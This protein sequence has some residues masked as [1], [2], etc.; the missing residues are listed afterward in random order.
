MY[1]LRPALI[2]T[3]SIER[4]EKKTGIQEAQKA[5]SLLE[6]AFVKCSKGKAFF[7]G[8]CIGYLDMAL[9]CFL[10]WLR[11]SE[12][13]NSLKLLDE[14][15]TPNLFRWAERFCTD[16]ALKDVMPQNEKLFEFAEKVYIP[17]RSSSSQV[18]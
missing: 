8:D 17:M 13:F 2:G 7:G 11:V 10:G 12:K 18:N 3:V 5:L 6:D 9:G 15:N 1:L 4:G 16:G 14:A